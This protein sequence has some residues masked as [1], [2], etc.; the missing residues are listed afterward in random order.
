MKVSPGRSILA[1][2]AAGSCLASA[3]VAGG[4]AAGGALPWHSWPGSPFG[5]GHGAEVALAAPAARPTAPAIQM[6]ASDV[7]AASDG[8]AAPVPVSTRST[9]VATGEAPTTI[10]AGRRAE[11]ED[12][13]TSHLPAS[14]RSKTGERTP[15]TTTTPAPAA[16]APA[17]DPAPPAPVVVARASSRKLTLSNVTTSF[18]SAAE[19][20]SGQPE[21]KV[22]MQVAE[23][24]ATVA[25]KTVAL[26]LRLSQT[27]V[28]AIRAR[29][30]DGHGTWTPRVA[31]SAQVDVV[32]A[33]STTVAGEPA[34]ADGTCVRV[35][36]SLAPTTTD[37][38]DTT[39]Q[40]EV[41]DDQETLSNSV[42]VTVPIDTSDLAATPGDSSGQ[43]TDPAP[44]PAAGTPSV[45]SLPLT[46]SSAPDGTPTAPATDSTTV[47]V[48]DAASPNPG[49]GDTSA[50]TV[51]A[52]LDIIDP[53]AAPATPAVP[54]PV[55]PASHE[56]PAAAPADPEP[57]SSGTGDA[58]QPATDAPATTP[59]AA[60]A[61]AAPAEP[62]PA[63]A[64]DPARAP[65]HEDHS[66]CN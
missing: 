14:P 43:P 39:P 42:K 17:E 11:R 3:V 52:Q 34:C 7:S 66:D 37:A 45:V 59:T 51:Q 50:V 58:E 57:D 19:T 15:A 2:I 44:A 61:P 9:P 40:V 16:A 27:Q 24:A 8:T 41:T 56:D 21:L 10:G 55:A 4:L 49:T 62:A 35:Q 48:P 53:P 18:A 38:G 28:D 31:L 65:A 64:A 1:S 25:P 23:V 54:V 6:P 60:P 63:P 47:A 12:R 29:G 30:T 5:T 46:S 33:T 20:Q 36:M 22:T 26:S 32:D 13:T